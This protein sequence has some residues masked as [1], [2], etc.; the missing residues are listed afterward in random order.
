M[1][2]SR[3]LCVSVGIP[4]ARRRVLHFQVTEHSDQG[5]LAVPGQPERSLMAASSTLGWAAITKTMGMEEVISE[6]LASARVC[7]IHSTCYRR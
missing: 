5:R 7:N 3:R 2:P 4:D 6:I 1:A